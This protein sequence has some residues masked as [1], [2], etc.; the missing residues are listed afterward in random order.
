MFGWRKRNE[1][2]EWREYVRT[3][4]LVRREKRRQHI[5]EIREAAVNKVKEAGERGVRAGAAGAD[6]V[7]RAAK[8]GIAEAGR[9]LG[10]KARD[11]AGWLGERMAHGGAAA[12]SAA[13]GLGDAAA[14]IGGGAARLGGA[15]AQP[16]AAFAQERH[17]S[18]RKAVLALAAFA[19]FWAGAR[20]WG[21]G[22]DGEAKLAALV[23]VLALAVAGLI[24]MLTATRGS[25]L[26]AAR[27]RI[28]SGL[29][30]VPLPRGR[31]VAAGVVVLAAVAG[32][33]SWLRT[34][35]GLGL[36]SPLGYLT[37]T[38]A[39]SGRATT[40]A[41]TTGR[42]SGGDT[43]VSGRATVLAGDTIRVAGQKVRLASIEAPERDQKCTTGSARTWSCGTAAVQALAS[44]ISSRPVRCEV[45]QAQGGMEGTCSVD[46]NDLAAALVRGGHVFAEA[47]WFARYA[48]EEAEARN[49][50][51]GVWRSGAPER[52][53]AFRT[54]RWDEARRTAPD[55]C[56]IKGQKPSS[57]KRVYVLPWSAQY[58]RVKVRVAR[59]E[60]WFCSEAEAQAAGWSPIEKS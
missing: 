22:I 49:A 58:D 30:A 41:G 19:A 23:T 6:K 44:R 32:G 56:P 33:W 35:T 3:T 54:K 53:A 52:P 21:H 16:L 29:E 18:V 1:G 36:N 26:A 27:D 38:S 48:S 51:V 15:V 57:D 24:T 25:G 13:R 60:R 7:G 9:S 8:A 12:G 45:T 46:G 14:R 11:G 2:F 5:E 59:G 28:G 50:K 34:G 47:G 42:A 17:E 4:I 20:Y 40:T 31:T 43:V 39:P 10:D 37:S 55:G